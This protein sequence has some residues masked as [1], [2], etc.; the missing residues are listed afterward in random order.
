MSLLCCVFVVYSPMLSLYGG[1]QM[2]S[3]LMNKLM[4][5]WGVIIFLGS[6]IHGFY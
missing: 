3:L 1:M 4:F 6:V 5:F 2:G